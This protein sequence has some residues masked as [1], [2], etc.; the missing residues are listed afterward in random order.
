MNPAASAPLGDG[1]QA[2][3][4]GLWRRAT[5]R[6]IDSAVI[7]ASLFLAPWLYIFSVPGDAFFPSLNDEGLTRSPFHWAAFAAAIA[8]CVAVLLYELAMTAMWGQTF[9]K[10]FT[11]IEVVS[12]VDGVEP[13]WGQAF[14]RWFVPTAVGAVCGWAALLISGHPLWDRS[15]RGLKA[16]VLGA[17][18]SWTMIYA[19]ALW[20]S[21][22]RGWPDKAAGTIVVRA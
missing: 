9:G 22:G 17:V 10:A 6:A 5:A 18:L 15:D 19:S 7:G 1:Q 12:H 3:A 2:L 16:L 4:A 14:V 21:D 8:I 20:N 11:G 13:L